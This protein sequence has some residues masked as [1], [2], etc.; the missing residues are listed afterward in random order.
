MI[1]DTLDHGLAFH[2]CTSI[3]PSFVV[4]GLVCDEGNGLPDVAPP[5]GTPAGEDDGRFV[6]FSLGDI[7]S[8]NVANSTITLIYRA[9]VLN[10]DDNQSSPTTILN[11][12]AAWGTTSVADTGGPLQVTE[13]FLAITKTSNNS[14]ANAGDL[15][16]FDIEIQHSGASTAPA[17]DVILHD[18]IPTGLVYNPAT[19][20]DHRL[21]SISGP[22][23]TAVNLVGGEVLAEWTVLDLTDVAV[24]RLYASIDSA[25]PTGT[26]IN[27]VAS[28]EWTSLPGNLQTP[29][30]SSYNDFSTERWYD[31]DD[32]SNVNV[33]GGITSADTV[34]VGGIP[35]PAELPQTGFA[36]NQITDLPPKPF[37]YKNYSEGFWM[38]IPILGISSPIVGVPHDQDGWDTT[39][40]WNQLGYLEGTAFPTWEGNTAIT[41]HVFLPDGTPGPFQRIGLLRWGNEVII[42][43]N[44]LK[45]T[46]EVR[47]NRL[48]YPNNTSILGHAEEDWVTLIT[49]SYFSQSTNQYRY[50]IAVKAVLM[51]IEAE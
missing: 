46:Y 45:Y 30:R 21:E 47:S 9:V 4:A 23:P 32:P 12:T 2:S 44:G 41:G 18:V 14:V 51:S 25:V 11:N 50:R 29:P 33:Y 43:A 24:V 27:N 10:I 37:E 8:P 15:I 49:C 16:S 48:V 3:T 39:W 38:E 22:A 40:L 26:V 19:N 17:Y 34:T 6:Y 35:L 20:P 42:H 1:I 36:P 7:T 31:P 28:V 13:P 5:V